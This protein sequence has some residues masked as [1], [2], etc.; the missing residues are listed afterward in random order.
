MIRRAMVL[1]AGLGQR[2]R[3]L[4]A[5]TAKPLLL[6][7]GRSLLD[8]ALDR[9]AQ[10]GI[11]QVVV[12]AHWKAPRVAEALAARR[13]APR[14]RLQLEPTCWKPAAAS[15][16]P[17]RCSARALRRGEWRRPLAGRPGAGAGPAGPGL[18]P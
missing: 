14:T 10:A 18:R 13:E 6:L 9:L 1:A 15:V 11:E 12:N 17:C 3:P 8:H 5:E 16:A 7:Q 2:M 4:T